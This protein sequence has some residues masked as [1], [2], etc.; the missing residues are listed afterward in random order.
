MEGTPSPIRIRYGPTGGSVTEAA[1][2]C[3]VDGA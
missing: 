2:K 1:V 3:K